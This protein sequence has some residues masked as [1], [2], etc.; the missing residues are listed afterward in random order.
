MLRLAL[1]AAALVLITVSSAAAQAPA[2]PAPLRPVKVTPAETKGPVFARNPPRA[3][4]PA[5]GIQ[6]YVMLR[7]SDRKLYAGVYKAGP[8]DTMSDGWKHDEFMHFLEG[9]VKL[10]SEDGTVTQVNAGDAVTLPMG[11]KGRWETPGYTKY[12]VIYDPK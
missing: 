11:W 9:S 1:S 8:S 12:Y 2:S 4:P 5:N 7:S 10:T 3:N 6:E